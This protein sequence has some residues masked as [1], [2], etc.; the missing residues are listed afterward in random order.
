MPRNSG[1]GIFFG[2]RYRLAAALLDA[3]SWISRDKRRKWPESPAKPVASPDEPRISLVDT[4]GT[5]TGAVRATDNL[6]TGT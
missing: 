5:G 3:A 2:V 1:E 4:R 6:G